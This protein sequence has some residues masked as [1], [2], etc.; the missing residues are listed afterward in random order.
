MRV[1]TM[2]LL[3]ENGGGYEL[4]LRLEEQNTWRAWLSE[5]DHATMLPYLASPGTWS[6]LMQSSSS[7]SL[8]ALQLRVRALLFD[9]AAA[10]LFLE[11]VGAAIVPNSLHPSY[12]QLH[13]DSVYFSL[14]Q[15]AEDWACLQADTALALPSPNL[16]HGSRTRTNVGYGQMVSGSESCTT[17]E[18]W[19]NQC[20]HNSHSIRMD[21]LARRVTQQRLSFGDQEACLRTP[22]GMAAYLNFTM[23]RCKRWPV[24]QADKGTKPTDYP[25]ISDTANGMDAN[26]AGQAGD[27]DASM[28][29]EIMF[30]GNCVPDNPVPCRRRSFF[31]E[32]DFQQVFLDDSDPSVCPL[33]M[34]SSLGILAK[35]RFTVQTEG[36][37]RI[38]LKGSGIGP[39]LPAG[40]K[41]ELTG[42]AA[43]RMLQQT[44][45]RLVA[46][47]GF[48]G[49]KQASLQIL[50]D[51]LRCHMCKL[52]RGLR[53]LVDSYSKKCSQQ[54]LMN[55]FIHGAAGSNVGDLMVYA[56]TLQQAQTQQP[57]LIHSLQLP[58]QQIIGQWQANPPPGTITMQMQHLQAQ[59]QQQ[60]V[61][62]ERPGRRRQPSSFAGSKKGERLE[63]LSSVE[64]GQDLFSGELDMKAGLLQLV[65]QPVSQGHMGWH[66][67][68]PNFT[69]LPQAQQPPPV[70]QHF[71]QQ[72]SSLQIPNLQQQSSLARE[73]GTPKLL[74]P[75]IE[76]F[77]ELPMSDS[78]KQEIDDHGEGVQMSPGK[79]KRKQQR[80]WASNV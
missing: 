8:L 9:K 17:G 26:L 23:N 64:V 1:E 59:G 60:Q 56:K 25:S 66:H 50:C 68:A 20:L 45:V 22:E 53:L 51:L 6:K 16:K 58:T 30:P 37:S 65:G 44:V 71:K 41:S 11:H 62:L 24:L 72:L 5:R 36:L 31:E 42:D 77:G 32:N 67:Q 28:L 47:A 49:L 74:H 48:E 70:L 27:E 73:S 12:L 55:M 46:A 4:A 54:E 15:D 69:G 40:L 10:C 79:R 2:G 38:D 80:N 13:A 18:L 7:S 57:A 39:P 33:P 52:A 63:Q 3:G 75:R 78:I 34:S 21:R 19:Y 43:Q 29:P 14:E 61:G 76:G 35:D